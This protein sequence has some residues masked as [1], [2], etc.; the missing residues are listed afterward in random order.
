MTTL[1]RRVHAKGRVDQLTQR[2]RKAGL[3]LT[4]KRLGVL[5]A[6]RASRSHPTAEELY[7][8]LRKRFPSISRNTVYLNLEALGRLG[9][10][11]EFW[12]D[13][14]A[15]RFE[16]NSAP[17]DHAVC[18]LCKTI[19]DISDP[20]LRRLTV[21]RWVAARFKVI[22]HRVDFFGICK[23]CRVRPRRKRAASMSPTL[24]K[25]GLHGPN[26]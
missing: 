23:A 17:H 25:E 10:T 18:V 6:L 19:I 16:P 8:A 24:T 15:A 26:Q 22:R 7:R 9:E 4:R 3:R 5:E 12:I 2:L 13:R 21:P 11:S 1:A 20:A 14:E